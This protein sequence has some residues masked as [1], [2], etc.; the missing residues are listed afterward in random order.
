[1]LRLL[2]GSGIMLLQKKKKKS[3]DIQLSEKMGK[4]LKNMFFLF[5]FILHCKV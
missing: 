1:M 5:F 3:F 4:F 2:F